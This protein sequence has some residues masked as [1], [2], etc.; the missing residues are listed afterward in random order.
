MEEL[1]NLA[2]QIGLK[3]PFIVKLARKIKKPEMEIFYI[4]SQVQ[5]DLELPCIISEDQLQGNDIK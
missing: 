2:K 3:P 4:N 1:D 5:L